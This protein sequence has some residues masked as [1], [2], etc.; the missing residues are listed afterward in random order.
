MSHI[1]ILCDVSG[2]ALLSHSL[3]F[4]TEEQCDILSKSCLRTERAE[5]AVQDSMGS[6]GAV[7]RHHTVTRPTSE[8]SI[9]IRIMFAS[10]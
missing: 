8:R 7:G 5:L 2:M 3:P 1:V 10:A 9:C 6:G 4:R